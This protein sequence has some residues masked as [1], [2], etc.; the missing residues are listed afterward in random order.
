MADHELYSNESSKLVLKGSVAGAA[1]P[2]SNSWFGESESFLG[3]DTDFWAEFGAEVGLAWEYTSGKSTFFAELSG[4][5]TATG[6]DDASGLTIG[7]SDQD[8]ATTEQAHIGW[9]YD[10]PFSGLEEDTFTV[11]IGRQD[12]LIG[13]GMLIADGGT[14][15]HTAVDGIKRSGRATQGVIV[16]RLREGEQVSSLAPVVGADDEAEATAELVTPA[17]VEPADGDAD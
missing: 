4:V 15:I 7:E 9:R 17:A 11:S 16:M 1:F 13:T 8:Q 12:Y 14:V 6:G 5:Y 3:D 2:G 10:D